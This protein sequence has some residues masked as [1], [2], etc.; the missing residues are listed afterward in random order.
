MACVQRS[1]SVQAACAVQWTSPLELH[2]IGQYGADAYFMFCRGD[3]REVHP[4]DKDL[5]RYR[6]WLADTDGLGQ[7][8]ERDKAPDFIYQP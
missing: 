1:G 3:W 7:G 2:G 4:T 5:L 8:L 6:N